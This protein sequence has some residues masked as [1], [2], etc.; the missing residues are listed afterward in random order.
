MKVDSV[1]KRSWVKNGAII[2]LALLVVLMFLSNTIMNHGLPEVA[3]QNT[4][5][6]PITARIR[7][8]GTATA[9]ES[10]EVT[11]TQTR[12]VNDVRVRLGDE[13]ETGDVLITLVGTASEELETLQAEL[14]DLELSL[15]RLL[16]DTS[17]DGDYARENR[18]IQNLR[19]ILSDAQNA[20]NALPGQGSLNYAQAA[21][22]RA[23]IEVGERQIAVD[24]AQG[25]M[26]DAL[27]VLENMYETDP[28]Y[29]AALAEFNRLSEI[30][31]IA[32]GALANAAVA[33]DEA[34]I[35]RDSVASSIADRPMREQAVRDAQRAVDDAVFDL[36]QQ[37]REGQITT[38][39]TAI[40]IREL[41]RKII[42]K[43]EELEALEQEGDISEL[44]SPV[45]GVVTAISISAGNQTQA[46]TPLI[47]IEVVDRGYVLSFPVTTEQSTRVRVGDNAEVDRGW[48][49]WGEEITA[50][51]VSIRNDPQ[52][53]TANRL[54]EFLVHGD[55][56]SGTQLNVTLNQVS[57]N[58]QTIVPNAAIR[59]DANGEFVLVIMSHHNPL[60]TRYIA[61]RVDVRVLASDD[62]HT[63]VSGGLFGHEF[64]ITQST[65]PID[66]GMQV[67]LVDNP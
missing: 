21:V 64:V 20:L 55:I 65:R 37:Q 13:V 4:A 28:L 39:N 25:Y 43:R 5:P 3:T 36:A 67:R 12:T 9:V 48:W 2:F 54:L 60:G 26:L 40:D 11:I 23:L 8:S 57:E 49:S 52:N 16:I 61:T 42:E 46:D 22:D 58:F 66:P 44:T 15:E 18:A 17:L 47:V 59:T 30:L 63:A 53:P 32:Q 6:G 33:R 51:L 24:S 7:G 27:E 14:H 10:H 19:G 41:N 29:P 56:E 31:Y 1:K 34:I 35:H 50:T 38:S 45:S 62:T